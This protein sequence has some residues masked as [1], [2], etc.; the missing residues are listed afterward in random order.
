MDNNFLLIPDFIQKKAAAEAI[1]KCNGVT[2]QYGLVLTPAQALELAETRTQALKGL[3]R[4]EF[5]G[6][7]I[8]KLI[9]VF[10]DSPFLFQNNYAETLHELIET[11]YYFKNESLDSISDDELIALMKKYFDENCRGSVDLLQSRE[12][13]KLAHNI[14]FGINDYTN[15]ED[16]SDEDEDY[17]E[18]DDDYE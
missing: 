9:L 17:E 5:G 12:L 13:E 3:G 16:S 14:R 7:I 15:L 10:C 4:I 6:G 1:I 11:F 18:E 2:G 8:D